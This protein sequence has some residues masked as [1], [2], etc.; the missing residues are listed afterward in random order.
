MSN[1]SGN[2]MSILPTTL[3]DHLCEFNGCL[4]NEL[5]DK[6]RNDIDRNNEF[7][8]QLNLITT[9]LQQHNFHLLGE[10]FTRKN[11]RKL[12]AIRGRMAVSVEKFFYLRHRRR[13]QYPYLPCVAVRGGRGHLSFY[14]LEMLFVHKDQ[15]IDIINFSH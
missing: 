4:I 5:G 12:L 14:P 7:L 6:M 8:R 9:H 3:I 15:V 1:Q 11:S 13:L 10:F 2:A